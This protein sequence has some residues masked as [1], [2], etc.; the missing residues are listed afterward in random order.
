MK[1]K[2]AMRLVVLVWCLCLGYTSASHAE[3][4]G[5]ERFSG[6]TPEL[7]LHQIGIPSQI[8]QTPSQTD[9]RLFDNAI[10]QSER[11][12]IY[13]RG[14]E[15]KRIDFLITGIRNDIPVEVFLA[16]STRPNACDAF[17]PGIA[18]CFELDVPTLEIVAWLR[19]SPQEIISA[20]ETPLGIARLETR[21]VSIP[22]RLS[23][24]DSPRFQGDEIFF[25]ALVVPA[26]TLDFGLS[27]ASEVDRFLIE[28]NLD[29]PVPLD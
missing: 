13:T 15:G 26:E 11:G 4:F 23:A 9:R 12:I 25:Q 27:Q 18:G 28:R 7:S 19:L 2:I 17:P 29:P 16:F 3:V 20:D 10:S 24:L 5:S 22:V 21:S 1:N 14:S 8:I 6:S